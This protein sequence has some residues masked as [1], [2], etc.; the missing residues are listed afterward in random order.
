MHTRP[1]P[2]VAHIVHQ[3]GGDYWGE[4]IQYPKA[5]WLQEIANGDSLLGYW[6]WVLAQAESDAVCLDMLTGHVS[7][8]ELERLAQERGW[9][10]EETRHALDNLG[11]SYGPECIVPLKNGRQLRTP[12]FPGLCSYIRVLDGGFELAF[13]EIDEFGEDPANVLGALIGAAK[14]SFVE[15]GPTGR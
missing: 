8:K 3:C 1:H 2:L 11:V 13:W 5:T 12:P 9:S 6:E 7:A 4:C 14:G 15:E 10:A